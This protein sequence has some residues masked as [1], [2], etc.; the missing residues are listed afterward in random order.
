MEM[1][2]AL[3]DKK[4]FRIMTFQT[5]FKSKFPFIICKSKFIFSFSWYGKSDLFSR[6][7]EIL[8][9]INPEILMAMRYLYLHINM[10]KIELYDQIF[11]KCVIFRHLDLNF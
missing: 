6:N 8:Q 7:G 10:H 11:Y 3:R 4:K 5:L 1:V 9:I 2:K